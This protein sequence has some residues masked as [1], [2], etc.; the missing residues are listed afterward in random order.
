MQRTGAVHRTTMMGQTLCLLRS[1]RERL[2]AGAG[3]VHSWKRISSG[4]YKPRQI[5]HRSRAATPP[6]LGL[7]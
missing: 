6:E 2:L 4:P 3:R 1:N 5:A 7:R